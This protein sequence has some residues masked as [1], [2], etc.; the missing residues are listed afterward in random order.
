M[1]G[2]EHERS[3]F[4]FAIAPHDGPPRPPALLIRRATVQAPS[5]KILAPHSFSLRSLALLVDFHAII[6]AANTCPAT[7]AGDDTARRKRAG[8]KH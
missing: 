6:G 1:P 5:E 2:F 3:S 4:G 8:L 7:S